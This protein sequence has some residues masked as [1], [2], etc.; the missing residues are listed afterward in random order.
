VAPFYRDQVSADRLR[1]AEMIALR[2]GRPWSPLDS[3][4]SRLASAAAYDPGAFR[5]FLATVMCLA[6][7]RDVLTRP[8]IADTVEWVG[9]KTP[10]FP[11]P[12][13]ERLLQLLAGR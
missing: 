10:P 9:D 5:A 7:P 3:P 11:G 13:R 1:L 2:E 4:M 8:D 6:L 12:D